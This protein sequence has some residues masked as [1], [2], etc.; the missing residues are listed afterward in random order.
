MKLQFQ[1]AARQVTGSRYYLQAGG[2]RML[3]DCG[4]FQEREYQDRN[5]AVSPM[6]P[7]DVDVL[8]LTHAH[9]DHC[10]L[11][12][13]LVNAGFRGK[14]FCTSATADLT[15]LILRDAAKIQEEDAEYKRRRHEKEGRKGPH[16][17]LPLYTDKDVDRALP[18]LRSVPYWKALALSENVSV[19]YHDAGHIL[20][21]AM[22]ELSV[23]Q[24]GVEKKIV[25]SGDIGQW[26]KPIIRDPSLLTAADYVVMEST[27]GD[28][29]HEDH[30]DVESQLADV[31]RRTAERGGNVVIPTFAVER[32]QE[33]MY[34]MSRLRQAGR[35]PAIP[36]ILDSPMAVDAIEIYRRHRDCFDEE[37]W[38]LIAQ[39]RSPLSFP[40]LELS[41]SVQESRAINQ[42]RGPAVIMSTSGMC[43]AGRIKHHLRQ[44]LPRPQCTI[45]FVG[46]QAHGTLGRQILEGNREVRIHGRQYPVRAETAQI[47]GFSGHADRTG[48]LKWLGA[49]KTPLK[50][51]FLTHG[52][53]APAL[54]L[55]EQIR[56]RF[57]LAAEVPAYLETVT[58]E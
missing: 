40:G 25:F 22:L 27:Y 51:V 53:E 44:N 28:R 5:W 48:L 39:G 1:G 7:G 35:I 11:I 13:R 29:D 15:E 26:R 17:E 12:P 16:P 38:K 58:L 31:V 57:K 43:T 54:A 49:F 3:I 41:H 10:G 30:G 37:T 52:E 2:L 45:L 42:R 20:G 32:A 18:L 23:K 46:F 56:E 33:L 6:P 21:S 19:V 50:R 34:H 4:M 55:K 36:L 14:I 9:V 47:Y 24:N 8:L